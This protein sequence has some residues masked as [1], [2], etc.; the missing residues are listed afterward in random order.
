M[1]FSFNQKN[2]TIILFVLA[3]LALAA[4]LVF[5]KIY[6]NDPIKP[7]QQKTELNSEEIQQRFEKALSNLGIESDWI[8]KKK[9]NTYIVKVPKDLPITVILN[10]IDN[11]FDKSEVLITSDEKKINSSTSLKISSDNKVKLTSEFSYNDSIE[12]NAG[13]I[14]IFVTDLQKLNDEKL[15]KIFNIPESFSILLVPS[16]KSL[17][18]LKNI[19]DSNKNY[20]ILLNDEIDDLEFKLDKNYS[21][22]RLKN[23]IRTIIGKFSNTDFYIIDNNSNLYASSIYHFIKE[24]FDKR[25]INLFLEDSVNNIKNDGK[26]FSDRITETKRRMQTTIILSAED[27]L[28]LQNEISE[29]RK[30]GYRFI[31]P[32][33]II[34]K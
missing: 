28:S 32:V 25:K 13:R 16:K 11:S 21:K 26:D 31:N 27:F 33:K 6:E 9:K 14:G 17:A 15:K 5:D 10:E 24:E 30:V 22:A 7:V 12:R 19:N 23:S 29:F 8:K 4:N 3:I 34:K 20:S 2:F 18:I 1:N